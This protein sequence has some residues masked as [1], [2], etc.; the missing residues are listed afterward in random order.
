M[1]QVPLYTTVKARFW[2]WLAGPKTENLLCCSLFAQKRSEGL[3]VGGWRRGVG[4]EGLGDS[5][6]DTPEKL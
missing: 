6:C 2:T 4:G 5:R 1:S 3:E